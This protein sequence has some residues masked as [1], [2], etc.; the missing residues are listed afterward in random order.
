MTPEN[1]TQSK[2]NLLRAN[3]KQIQNSDLFTGAEKYELCQ[4]IV[5]QMADAEIKLAAEQKDKIEKLTTNP[6]EAPIL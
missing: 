1:Q 6:T 2:L 4:P 3:L 5:K